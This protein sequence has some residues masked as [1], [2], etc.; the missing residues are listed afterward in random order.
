MTEEEIKTFIKEI[1][2]QKAIQ[3]E[4]FY[5][6]CFAPKS[7]FGTFAET[8]AMGYMRE[9]LENIPSESVMGL[10]CGNPVSIAEIRS[11][12]VVI[13]LGS[14]GGLDVFLASLKTGPQGKVIGIDITEEMVNKARIVAAHHGYKNV[15]F[16]QGEA[17]NIPFESNSADYVISNC[18]INLSSDKTKVFQEMFRVLK[19][20]GN[21]S[22]CDNVLQEQFPSEM[23]GDLDIWTHC[24]AGALLKQEYLSAI[25]EV[26]FEDVLIVEEKD[27]DTTDL[28]I[29]VSVLSITVK[30]YKPES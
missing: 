27:F 7:A 23:E 5:P 21:I 11:G 12:D 24:V 18:T 17:E 28:N 25:S 26:G 4:Q 19:S 3:S 6:Y 13:D 22:I 10:G 2:A 15:E 20:G 30:A 9:E 8:E 14:G 16:R 1:Y 29:P